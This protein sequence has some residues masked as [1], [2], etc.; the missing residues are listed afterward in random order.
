MTPLTQLFTPELVSKMFP[1][2]PVSNIRSNLPSVLDAL[3]QFG[4]GDRD[5]ALVALSTIRAETESFV[6]LREAK[7]KYNTSPTGHPFDLYDHRMDLGNLGEPEG[8]RYR[9]RGFVQLTGRFN[10]KRYSQALGYR[11]QFLVDPE[12]TN[13]PDIAAKILARFL[14]DRE[15][16]IRA[17]LAADDLAHVRRLVTGGAHGLDRFVDAYQRGAA[18]LPE[19][20]PEP[21]LGGDAA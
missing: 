20:V 16:E 5:M 13:Q 19:V 9:G 4:L 11:D 12:I 8:A 10:Y 17:A 2:T 7:S 18:L 3:Q 6:P 21:D 15:V 1:H 14:K